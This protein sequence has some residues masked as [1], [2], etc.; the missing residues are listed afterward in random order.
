MF[1]ADNGDLLW[2]ADSRPSTG[3]TQDVIH[4]QSKDLSYSTVTDIK[5]VDRNNDGIIDH[6]YLGDLA[7]QAFRI[8]LKI[9]V[10]NQHM[11]LRLLKF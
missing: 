9:M 1:D 5:T 10:L 8:D 6:L 2:F 4:L 3:I 11:I 7:G